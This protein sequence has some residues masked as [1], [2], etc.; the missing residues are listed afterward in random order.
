MQLSHFRRRA[1]CMHVRTSR[2]AACAVTRARRKA[3]RAH[4]HTCSAALGSR[5][6]GRMCGLGGPQAYRRKLHT[7]DAAVGRPLNCAQCPGCP[8]GHGVF[9]LVGTGQALSL[10]P[11]TT[12]PLTMPGEAHWVGTL[13]VF[14]QPVVC[15]WSLWC[16]T[17]WQVEHRKRRG[18]SEVL[19]R[20]HA[21]LPLRRCCVVL[22]RNPG[23]CNLQ[24]ED[25][26]CV[27]AYVLLLLA[28]ASPYLAGHHMSTLPTAETERRPSVGQRQACSTT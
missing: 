24:A 25:T 3:G 10:C 15:M 1:Q 5:L 11:V 8:C 20:G 23:S 17:E 19:C 21:M 27:H 9:A 7:M 14:P 28:L 22:T 2:T 13:P 4:T 12:A 26:G 6:G 18:A 16:L